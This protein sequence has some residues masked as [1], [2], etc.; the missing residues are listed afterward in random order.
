MLTTAQQ[1]YL[2]IASLPGWEWTK[3][4]DEMWMEKYEKVKDF[5]E[6]NKEYPS[7]YS[8]DKEEKRLA[9]WV[10]EQRQSKKEKGTCIL[11]EERIKLLEAIH[12]WQWDIFSH[13]WNKMFNTIKSFYSK[14]NKYPSKNSMDEEEKS[15][16]NWIYVQRQSKK[17]NGSC[18]LTEERI[19]QL[20][21]LPNWEWEIDLDLIW[22][23]NFDDVKFFYSKNN[24]YPSDY[25]KN[26]KEKSLGKWIGHQK[27]AKKGKGTYKLTPYRI[28]QL[29]SLPNWK[30]EI[31]FDL[32]WNERFESVKSF[33]SK[34]NKYPSQSLTNKK[35]NSLKQWINTQRKDKKESK[36]KED[37]IKLLETLPNWE[38][39]I[40]LDLKWNKKFESVKSFYSKNNKYPSQYSKDKE[41]QILGTWIGRQK[42]NKKKGKLTEEQI[43][44][45]E[46]F[47]NWKW[48]NS[49]NWDKTFNI[50]KSFYSKNNKYPSQYSKDKEEQILGMWIGRQ[51]TNKKKGKLTEGKIK[52]L[53]SIPN[54]KWEVGLMWNEKFN[55]VKYFYSKNNKYPS[56]YSKD[57]EEKTLGTWIGTQKKSQ[58][59]KGSGKLI[60]EQIKLLESLPNW[61]WDVNPD[62][63]NKKFESVKSFIQKNNK[64][65]SYK[66]ID[67]EEK[68]LNRWIDSQK[69]SKKGKGH[70]K[71]TEEQSNLLESLP[72]WKW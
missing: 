28:K 14:N 66:G 32:I 57:K 31:D 5:V 65:P 64:Y 61:K 2:K 45:L 43:K 67:K 47:P 68:R 6:I 51:K 15:F 69:Q 50:I 36:I 33:Y 13:N 8:M 40:D 37:R 72:N 63:W 20:E 56:I 30:W 49:D 3:T 59:G 27:Q 12:N 10:S 70:H 25:S 39:E 11:T 42:T 24:K 34:N 44:L 55:T 21:S 60:E 58:K 16:A 38:W 18:V 52:L 54:W 7:I 19:K 9:S 46:T 48:N 17:G 62:K 23:K 29:E 26:K 53:E 41:E 1:R 35:E 71:L 4:I 22:N